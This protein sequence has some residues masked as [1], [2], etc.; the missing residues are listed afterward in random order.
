MAYGD[1]DLVT[2]QHGVPTYGKVLPRPQGLRSVTALTTDNHSSFLLVDDD[3][4]I[5]YV[6]DISD[7]LI[8][9]IPIPGDRWPQDCTVVGGQ[10]WVGC[11]NGNIIVM[12]SQ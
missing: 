1:D 12:S 2:Y 3:S 6:L 4:H 10:L 9:T 11:Y 5:V 8:Y 7:N